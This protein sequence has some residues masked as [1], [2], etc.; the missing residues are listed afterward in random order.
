MHFFMP[1]RQPN[2]L[3]LIPAPPAGDAEKFVRAEAMMRA[4]Q[5]ALDKVYDPEA[6][7]QLQK[8]ARDY[9]ALIDHPPCDQGLCPPGSSARDCP[10]VEKE[11][12]APVLKSVMPPL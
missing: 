7:Q 9:C 4:L 2:S 5:E 6:D 3:R 8:L 11:E 12:A 1:S 10:L